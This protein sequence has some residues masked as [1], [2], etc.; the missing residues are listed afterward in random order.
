MNITKKILISTCGAALVGA[1]ALGAG[2]SAAG[3]T[4]GTT[5]L[6]HDRAEFICNHQSEI[7][8][9]LAKAETRINDR[10]A[11]LTT[12]RAQ[13]ESAGHTQVVAR[14]D[15]RLDRLHKLLD[16]VTKRATQLP[17][18]V[19]AHCDPATPTTPAS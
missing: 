10:I 3:P 15:V 12:R 18:W 4:S 9:R 7:S 17:V 5:G 11:T 6:A 14:I 8:D 2:A 13:A 16:R 1:L 19:A